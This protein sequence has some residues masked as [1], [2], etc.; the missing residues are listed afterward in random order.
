LSFLPRPAN[1]SFP[2]V[3]AGA[4]AAIYDGGLFESA[5]TV[6]DLVPGG[7]ATVATVSP[8]MGSRYDFAVLQPA[9]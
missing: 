9:P 2:S 3:T 8:T 1:M 7:V 6:I 4:V 5:P